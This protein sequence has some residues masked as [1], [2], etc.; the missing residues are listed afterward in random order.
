MLK[1]IFVL[2]LIAHL[3][4]AQSDKWT[5]GGTASVDAFRFQQPEATV[6]V[7]TSSST[8]EPVYR[9]GFTVG[10]VLR[11]QTK[12]SYLSLETGLRYGY[13]SWKS[14]GTSRVRYSEFFGPSD[15]ER[16]VLTDYNGNSQLHFIELP[17]LARAQK[18]NFSL[19]LGP[20][21]QVTLFHQGHYT[22]ESTDASTGEREETGSF[23]LSNKARPLTVNLTAGVGYQLRMSARTQLEIRGTYQRILTGLYQKEFTIITDQQIYEGRTDGKYPRLTTFQL[24]GVVTRI[25]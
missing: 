1:T 10:A 24:G 18:G 17:L 25:R 8:P 21:A 19:V 4:T 5:L 2:L 15:T 12:L 14:Q 3:A 13:R 22:Q 9:L 7:Q 11:R 23:A 16:E 20:S 6:L